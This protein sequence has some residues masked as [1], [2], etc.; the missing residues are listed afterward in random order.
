LEIELVEAM[1]DAVQSV[2]EAFGIALGNATLGL[3]PG[4]EGYQIPTPNGQSLE[5]YIETTI[6]SLEAQG[7]EQQ[8]LISGIWEMFNATAPGLVRKVPMVELLEYYNI[9]SALF[10]SQIAISE[11]DGQYSLDNLSLNYPEDFSLDF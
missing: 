2:S 9:G 5:E 8:N 11:N 7:L 1:H 4:D 3:S 10:S 6:S